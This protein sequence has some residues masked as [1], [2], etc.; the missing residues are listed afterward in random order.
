[1]ICWTRSARRDVSTGPLNWPSGVELAG[2]TTALAV[3]IHVVGVDLT[4]E[5]QMPVA[6]TQA[7]AS[8]ALAARLDFARTGEFRSRV[9]GAV[10]ASAANSLANP[11]DSPKLKKTRPANIGK[12]KL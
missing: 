5:T 6:T 12:L 1:M 4:H 7:I 9:S 8:A 2:L 3:L 10:D 11:P